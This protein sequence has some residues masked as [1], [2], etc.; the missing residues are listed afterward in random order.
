MRVQFVAIPVVLVIV[1]CESWSQEAVPRLCGTC[2]G[3]PRPEDGGWG[4]GGGT[5]G[6]FSVA[7]DVQYYELVPNAIPSDGSGS[8]FMEVRLGRDVNR[9]FLDNPSTFFFNIPSTEFHDD[10]I[11]NDATAGDRI[12]TSGSI[13]VNPPVPTSWLKYNSSSSLTGV[14]FTIFGSPAIVETTGET[15]K[16]L[17]NPEIGIFDSAQT[18]D[19][20]SLIETNVQ[21]ASHLVNV[22]R[23]GN[24]A[25]QRRL[26]SLN[27]TNLLQEL[28]A[29]LYGSL[30][31]DYDFILATSAIHGEKSDRFASANFTSGLHIKARQDYT[32]TGLGVF[33]NSA[34]YGSAGRLLSVNL[35][36]TATRGIEINNVVHEF[37]HQW[38]AF[39]SF[40]L[41]IKDDGAHWHHRSNI[42][43]VLGGFV[44]VPQGDGNIGVTS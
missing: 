24:P 28:T 17:I 10:G 23:D 5:G 2:Q 19:P 11:G 18:L 43:S 20:V 31:D 6:S 22:R 4:A 12:W 41:G 44:W 14:G 9:V 37:T 30:P 42:G 33:D 36:D 15:N 40:S 8:F 26:H 16:F 27:P 34:F 7:A 13:N 39:A 1:A 35:V 38:S 21:I 3:D 25:G 29:I 32:G